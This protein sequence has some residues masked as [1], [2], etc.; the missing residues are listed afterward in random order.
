MELRTCLKVGREEMRMWVTWLLPACPPLHPCLTSI[1]PCLTPMSL[2]ASLPPPP[3][4]SRGCIVLDLSTRTI[5]AEGLKGSCTASLVTIN[6]SSGQLHA[7]NL[8]DSGFMV[9]GKVAGSEVR[10][11]G[12]RGEGGDAGGGRLG[13]P[14]PPFPR[15]EEDEG[16]SSDVVR[17][18]SLLAVPPP[19]SLAPP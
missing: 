6:Q 15:G 16:R 1:T 14:A 19:S 9:L 3:P 8:G 12:G 2:L 13:G 18:F 11:E 5:L 4:F 10:R 7:A 17:T